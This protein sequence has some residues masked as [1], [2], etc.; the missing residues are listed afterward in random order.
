MEFRTIPL[1]L[2]QLSLSAVLRCGQSF[3]W[4]ALVIEPPSPKSERESLHAEPPT[5]EYRFALR[6][7]IVCLR[8]TRDALLYRALYSQRVEPSHQATLDLETESW[9]RDYF[10]LDVDLVDLYRQ[11]SCNDANFTGLKDR[12]EGIRMLRQDPWE[13]LIS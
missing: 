13:N 10:Q 1:S 2:Q 11:W 12:F 3:R 6:D 8:Q 5:H 4:H 9:I 7:R